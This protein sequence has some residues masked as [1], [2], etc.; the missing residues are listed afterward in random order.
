MICYIIKY[1][2]IYYRYCA[3]KWITK[4]EQIMPGW[5]FSE[6]QDLPFLSNQAKRDIE[7]YLKLNYIYLLTNIY[8][9]CEYFSEY[10]SLYDT[11]YKNT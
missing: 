11:C 4:C 10:F 6:L 2:Y 3:A 5:G 1:A 8:P 9:K 7:V